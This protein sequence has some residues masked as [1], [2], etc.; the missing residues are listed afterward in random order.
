MKMFCLKEIKLLN[1]RHTQ[2]HQLNLKMIETC[3]YLIRNNKFKH[4]IPVICILF[5]NDAW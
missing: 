4:F 3:N 2:T 1:C 5:E